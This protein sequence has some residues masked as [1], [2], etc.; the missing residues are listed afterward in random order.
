MGK[1]VL[2]VE[3]NEFSLPLLRFAVREL[4]LPHIQRLLSFSESSTFTEDTYDSGYLEPW[5]QWVS[6]HTGQ[7]SG[8]H[9]VMHLGDVPPAEVPQLW[10]MLSD[11][12]IT[13]GF[14]GVMNGDRKGAKHCLFFLPD[15]WTFVEPG[16]PAE[17][18][19][20]LDLPRYFTKNRLSP[21][22]LVLLGKGLKLFRRMMAIGVVQ[23]SW[24]EWGFWLRGLMRFGP[25]PFVLFSIFEYLSALAFLHYRRTYRP[26]VAAIFLNLIAHAQHYYWRHDVTRL[27]PEMVFVLKIANRIMGLLWAESPVEQVTLVMNALT[28][29]NTNQESTWV[30]YVQKRPDLFLKEIGV[31]TVKIEQLMTND[32]QAFFASESDRDLAHQRLQD[33]KVNGQ[34]LLFVDS[35]GRDPLRLFYRLDY[36]EDLGPEAVLQFEGRTFAFYDHFERIVVRTGKHSP[37]GSVFS[38]GLKLPP[39]LLNHELCKFIVEASST[40]EARV[41]SRTDRRPL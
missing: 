2:L 30:L 34:R 5:V 19:S 25:K 40:G 20:I 13:S 8:L 33:L 31:E 9:K 24:A 35:N 6:V 41:Q 10:E 14:W 27:A 11:R 3:L 15:P 29:T 38:Q 18:E 37:H 39:R 32:A 36:F 23:R 21:R 4:N 12:Q 26:R 7:P 1:S 17:I 16:F 28:Q 22:R